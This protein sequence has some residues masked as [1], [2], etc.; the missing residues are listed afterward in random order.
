[1]RNPVSAENFYESSGILF[2]ECSESNFNYFYNS[3]T[4]YRYGFDGTEHDAEDGYNTTDYRQYDARIGRWLSKDPVVKPWES[5]YAGFSNNPIY[6]KDPMGSDPSGPPDREGTE[7]ED[8]YDECGD[9]YL[10]GDG[11]W[12][13]VAPDATYTEQHATPDSYWTRAGVNEDK[14]REQVDKRCENSFYFTQ[15]GTGY[16]GM[17]A[18]VHFW[19]QDHPDEYR[20]AVYDLY[21]NGQTTINGWT[22]T[23]PGDD[24]ATETGTV[25]NRGMDDADFVLFESIRWS[26]T[27]FYM[28]NDLGDF[29]TP[30]T[31]S[32]VAKA[33]GYQSADLTTPF[34]SSCPGS[35]T[36]TQI[37]TLDAAGVDVIMLI[38]TDMLNGS[39][40]SLM[41]NHYVGYAG[42]WNE[43][44]DANGGKRVSFD[45]FTWGRDVYGHKGEKYHVD[46]TWGEFSNNYYGTILL[47]K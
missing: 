28:Q 3:S 7:N 33:M 2:S 17:A 31:L 41:S 13:F 10:Y 20:Q 15:T 25:T 21:Y 18:L 22:I 44:T 26:T 6:F 23:K 30:G 4:T 12:T 36:G 39:M 45:V 38:N 27:G 32:T 47:A 24:R 29:Y 46:C 42:G 34:W 35:L 14:L 43:Y 5:P 19:A 16:C 11:K 9:H 40:K 8:Y 37:N 1:M